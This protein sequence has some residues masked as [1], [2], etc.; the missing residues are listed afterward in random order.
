MLFKRMVGGRT[1]GEG[2]STRLGGVSAMVTLPQ[3]N[4]SAVKEKGMKRGRP[5]VSAKV[6]SK[7]GHS[8]EHKWRN[9]QETAS[10]SSNA[11]RNSRLLHRKSVL[12]GF[13]GQAEGGQ[14][15]E[16]EGPRGLEED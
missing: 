3:P 6:A 16:N 15:G 9:I 1:Q 2:G 13:R 11:A 12:D 5:R 14:R 10:W 8:G 7:E 4:P